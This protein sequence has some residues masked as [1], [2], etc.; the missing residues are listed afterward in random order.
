MEKC[1]K[2]PLILV[3][4]FG[5]L[6]AAFFAAEQIEHGKCPVH[7]MEKASHHAEKQLDSW[8]DK[9]FHGAKCAKKHASCFQ[10]KVLDGAKFAKHFADGLVGKLHF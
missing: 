6:I 5:F 2:T 8:H 3:L 7:R 4:F 9:V 1:K 10:D